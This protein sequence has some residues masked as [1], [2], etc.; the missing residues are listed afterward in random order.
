[1][2]TTDTVI[3]CLLEM[4]R[5]LFEE[6]NDPDADEKL[7]CAVSILPAIINEEGEDRA[8]LY[9][10]RQLAHAMRESGDLDRLFL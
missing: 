9:L 8:R 4:L 7:V 2:T 1:M 10:V 6:S 3:N 5:R